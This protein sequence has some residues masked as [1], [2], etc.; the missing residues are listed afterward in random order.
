MFKKIF[1]AKNKYHNKLNEVNV[2]FLSSLTTEEQKKLF[3]SLSTFYQLVANKND[4]HNFIGSIDD[5]FS[6]YE[7]IEIGQFTYFNLSYEQD[8]I[9]RIDLYHNY[10]GFKEN[11]RIIGDSAG[12]GF[13]IAYPDKE[14]V[15]YDFDYKDF[16]NPTYP[17]IYYCFNLLISQENNLNLKELYFK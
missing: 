8:E 17:N 10:D 11:Y 2:Q 9:E 13:Y 14:G 12:E 1:A 3:F 5:F 6:K 4:T 15:W 7:S 16:Y